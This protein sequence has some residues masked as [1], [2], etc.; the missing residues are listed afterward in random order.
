MTGIE[1]ATDSKYIKDEIGYSD[2]E[3]KIQ[4]ITKQNMLLK[5]EIENK[6]NN[7]SVKKVEKKSRNNSGNKGKLVKNKKK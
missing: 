7:R 1:T 2:L 6:N 4:E 3:N 5:K